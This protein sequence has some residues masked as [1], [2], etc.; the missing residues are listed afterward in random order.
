MIRTTKFLVSTK[1]LGDCCKYLAIFTKEEKSMLGQIGY[2]CK[3]I[4][5]EN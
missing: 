5:M 3:A 2:K 1:Q 4:F